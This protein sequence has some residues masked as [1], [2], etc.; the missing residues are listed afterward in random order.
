MKRIVLAILLAVIM[1]V[2]LLTVGAAAVDDVPYIDANSATQTCSDY[3]EVTSQTSNWTGSEGATWYVVKSDVQIN[4]RITVTGDVH[5]ILADGRTLNATR[6]ISVTSD[7]SLTIYGQSEGTGKLTAGIEGVE[8]D[9]FSPMA[10]YA[11]I[12]GVK[13]NDGVYAHGNITINGGSITAYGGIAAAGIG[14]GMGLL[15]KTG[16]HGTITIN[17]GN[18]NATGGDQGAGIGDGSQNNATGGNIIINGGGV[19]A[20]G[21][22][23]A[24]GIGGGKMAR[25]TPGRSITISGGIV[26]ATGGSKGA[27]IGSGYDDMVKRSIGVIKINGSAN[28]TA[29]GGA[30]AAGIGSSYEGEITG[31]IQISGNVKVEATGG[32]S[33]SSIL[34]AGAGIGSGGDGGKVGNITILGGTVEA[35]GGNGSTGS[36]NFGGAGIGSGG[37]FVSESTSNTIVINAGTITATGGTGAA[38][39]G[40]GAGSSSGDFST[41]RTV[42]GEDITGKAVIYASSITDTNTGDWHGIIF[43]EEKGQ[44]YGTITLREDLTLVSGQTLTVPE[45]SKLIVPTEKAL[46]VEEGAAL[47]I[48]EKGNLTNNGTVISNGTLTST[49]TISGSG[50]FTGDGTEGVNFAAEFNRTKYATLNAAIKAANNAENGGTVTLLKNVTISSTTE[51]MDDKVTLSVDSGKTLTV[52]DLTKLASGTLEIKAGGGLNLGTDTLVGTSGTIKLTSG[53]V[54]MKESTVTLTSGSEAEIPTGETFYL[55][56]GSGGSALNAVIDTD[57]VLTVNGTLKAVSGTPDTGSHVTVNGTL[58]VKGTLTIALKADV[59]VESGGTLNLPAMTKETMGSNTPGEG[60]KGDIIVNAGAKLTYATADVLGGETPLLTLSTGSA[61]LNL[62]NANDA[63]NPSVSLTLNGTASVASDLKALWVTADG[64]KTFVPM[65]I[66]VASGSEA[67]VPAGK[68]LN[69]VNGS[70]LTVD[71]GATFTVA[72]DGILEVHSTAKFGDKAKVSGKVY[73][74]EANG[75][76]NPMNGASI[77]LTS[78]GEVY[79]EKTELTGTSITPAHMTESKETYKSISADDPT[80]FKNEWTLSYKVTL[81]PTDGTWGDLTAVLWTD[82]NGSLTLPTDTPT[83]TGHTFSGWDSDGNG[84]VDFKPGDTITNISEDLELKAVWDVII[85]TVSFD[86]DGGSAVATKYVEHGSKVTKPADPTKANYTFVGWYNGETL[87]NFDTPVTSDITLKAVWK[88][89]EY[90]VSFN[91]AGG[92]TVPS[93]TVEHGKTTNLPSAPSK[94]GYIFLG[95]R[96]GNVTYGA[97]DPVVVTSDM[98]FYAV[99]ANMPDVTPGDDPDEPVVAFPFNDVSVLDWFYDAV[100]YVWENELMNGTDVNQF[101]PNSPLTRAM[102]WAVLARVDGETISGDSWMTEAQAWAVE[103]GVSDGTDPTGY[104]TREQL[105]TMLYRF[106]GEPAGAADISGYPDAASISDWAA[107]AMAWAVKVGLIEGD[108]VGALNPTANSTRA[109]AATFFMRFSKTIL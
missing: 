93:K 61:T 14:G 42:S 20:K 44:V 73:V 60:M 36:Y 10:Y 95:W 81:N 100:Y 33:A 72:K 9:Y 3:T 24:A 59:T 92:S 4:T 35:T 26:N 106:A 94:P 62:G 13:G 87:Y 90:T 18:V 70:S 2:S 6:G 23:D 75:G 77:T 108:D 74:F 109:H 1:T 85:C 40:S 57:A 8:D 21:G 71:E 53:S 11:G 28:V 37:G 83:W 102:V 79:A 55:M 82:S 41:D 67:T 30:G 97:G 31:A 89:N 39:I 76:T 25:N 16:E 98:T 63:E 32:D 103:S 46:V 99:W 7:N 48:Q 51:K 52:N 19:T 58:D 22:E 88:L 27:G 50:T 5:L 49:G 45:G 29:Q 80:T 17:G 38:G 66:T 91:T 96:N 34:G 43:K 101:S 104:V 64:T 15:S 84:T 54:T 12:G 78:T 107:D 68:V 56:L 65:A 47:I 69:L 105:V 86:S